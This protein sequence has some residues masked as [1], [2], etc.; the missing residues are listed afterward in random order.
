ME[1]IGGFIKGILRGVR[2]TKSL[3]VLFLHRRPPSWTTLVLYSRAVFIFNEPTSWIDSKAS[4]PTAYVDWRAGTIPYSYPVPSPHRFFKNS[5]SELL[6]FWAGAENPW[7]NAGAN[8]E[9]LSPGFGFRT[10]KSYKY[11]RGDRVK[12]NKSAMCMLATANI[13]L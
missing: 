3:R 2:C 6:L 12:M 13:K 4:I 9:T 5:S 11:R 10:E 1:P 7:Q 8:L